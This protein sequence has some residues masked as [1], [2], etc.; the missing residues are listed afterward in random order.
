M[1]IK[2][3]PQ[4]EAELNEQ[5]RGAD[6][7]EILAFEVIQHRFLPKVP[8]VSRAMTGSED[9]SRQQSTVACPSLIQL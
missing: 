8:D 7:P 4:L 6:A 1:V 5:A 2:L 9:S 3:T